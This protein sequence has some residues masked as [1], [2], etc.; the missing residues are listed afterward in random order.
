MAADASFCVSREA[1]EGEREFGNQ[2]HAFSAHIQCT[3]QEPAI[4]GQISQDGSAVTVT[5]RETRVGSISS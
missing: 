2:T 3:T 1:R 4:E 5:A